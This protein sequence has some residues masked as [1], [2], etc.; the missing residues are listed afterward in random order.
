MRTVVSGVGAGATEIVL[1]ILTS[2]SVL[3]ESTGARFRSAKI[4]DL[5]VAP[6]ILLVTT[7]LKSLAETGVEE[8]G[9]EGWG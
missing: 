9:E 1:E 4:T 2:C 8:E 6:N 3:T 7:I 5:K